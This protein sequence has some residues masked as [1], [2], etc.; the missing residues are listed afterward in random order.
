MSKKNKNSDEKSNE[1]AQPFSLLNYDI[2]SIILAITSFS[3]LLSF[4]FNFSYFLS[5][6][7]SLLLLF[8]TSDYLASGVYFVVIT[9]VSWLF[10]ELREQSKSSFPSTREKIKQRLQEEKKKQQSEDETQK[11]D[12]QINKATSTEELLD[13][14]DSIEKPH[15]RGIFWLSILFQGIG[16][17]IWVLC[18]FPRLDWLLASITLHQIALYSTSHPVIRG[19]RFSWKLTTFFV[20]AILLV[21]YAGAMC[22][23]I[24]PIDANKVRVQYEENGDL[25]EVNGTIVRVLSKSLILKTGEEYIALDRDTPLQ[26]YYQKNKYNTK[27]NGIWRFIGDVA[28][29]PDKEENTATEEPKVNTTK[30]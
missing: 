12:K 5:F 17:A 21:F 27:A 2:T 16:V 3:V 30:N 26:I 15:R 18:A 7:P 23:L 19:D 22:T 20:S 6:R 11:W 13:I 10:L 25:L 4:V 28:S 8:S 14:L 24:L 1:L 9:F 29:S